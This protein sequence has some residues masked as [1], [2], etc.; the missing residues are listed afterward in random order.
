MFSLHDFWKFIKQE[1]EG[2]LGNKDDM[3]LWIFPVCVCCVFICVCV[4]KA[5]KEKDRGRGEE[6]KFA[7]KSKI[8]PRDTVNTAILD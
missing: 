3:V 8:R 1:R 7:W 5:K 6:E 4:N 2:N